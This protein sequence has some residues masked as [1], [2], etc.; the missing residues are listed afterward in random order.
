MGVRLAPAD[1][2]KGAAISLSKLFK[3]LGYAF[4]D[5]TSGGL[6]YQQKI[7]FS[8]CFQVHFAVQ[9]K[10]EVAIPVLILGIITELVQPKEIV[11]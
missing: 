7:L 8:R 5:I 3:A 10:R 11:A 9:V 6:S 2:A 1:W 4:L